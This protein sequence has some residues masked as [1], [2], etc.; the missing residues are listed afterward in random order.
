MIDN[1]IVCALFTAGVQDDEGRS[2]LDCAL[3]KMYEIEGCVDTVHYLIGRGC[4]GD[5]ERGQLL[6]GACRHGNLVMVKELVEQHKVDPNS[7]CVY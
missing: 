1:N 5:K 4:G 7:E 6:W 2:P 3:E